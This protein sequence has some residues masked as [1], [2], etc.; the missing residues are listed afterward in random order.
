MRGRKGEIHQA[1]SLVTTGT[2]PLGGSQ[3]GL[4]F[5]GIPTRVDLF[6]IFLQRHEAM[7]DNL[8]MTAPRQVIP[9][10]TFM[11]TRRVSERRFFLR[12]D[13]VVNSI[14]E[15]CIGLAALKHG[16]LLHCLA[17]L[18]NHYHLQA[19]DPLGNLPD[20]LRDANRMIAQ[21]LNKYWN[22]KEALWSS[23]KP[24]V[25]S[26]LDEGAQLRNIIYITLNPVRA[27]LVSDYRKWPGVLYSARDWNSA[28]KTVKRP[29]YF[30]ADSSVPEQITL[31][32]VPPPALAARDLEQV[33]QEVQE[34]IDEEQRAL[35][36]EVT[37]SGRCFMGVKRIV[38]VNPFDR[39]T[40]Q[41]QS[42]E[43][44]PRISASDP[45]VM[46]KGKARLKYFWQ[47]Y[48]EAL[49]KLRAGVE[50]VFPY[51]TFWNRR[52]LGVPCEPEYTML[53]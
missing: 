19:T 15:F 33:Y 37:S 4:I 31:S 20:F 38:E 3:P 16:I 7:T 46:H 25:V 14:I 17:V 6:D 42:N 34:A 43:V 10:D 23:D 41:E 11:T 24:S 32:F 1:Q 45:E 47:V 12:P 9:G 28:G 36:T 2:G 8:D 44:N 26:L 29:E 50:A 13:E 52:F 21:C 39:P 5:W 30:N 51:G 49:S 40:T 18:T 48:R 35:R 22:R 27:G 53:L